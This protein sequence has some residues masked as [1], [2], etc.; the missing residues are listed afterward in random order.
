MIMLKLR[1]CK[2]YCIYTERERERGG[3][4]LGGDYL[5][6]IHILEL[7]KTGYITICTCL[8]INNNKTKELYNKMNKEES[9]E[10]TQIVRLKMINL[11]NPLDLDKYSK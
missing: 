1:F 8:Q 6:Y 3:L 10:K 4:G 9:V 2:F 5:V 11:R 7:Y